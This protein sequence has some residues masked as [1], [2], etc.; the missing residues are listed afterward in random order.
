MPEKAKV[1]LGRK[2]VE[3]FHGKLSG[4]IFA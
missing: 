4:A 1:V 3:W 2:P